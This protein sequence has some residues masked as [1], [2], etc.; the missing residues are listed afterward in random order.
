MYTYSTTIRLHHTDA[1]GFIY[2]PNYF[3][4]AT[5]CFESFLDTSLPLSSLLK[6]DKLNFPVVHAAVDCKIPLIVSNQIAIEMV[7][8]KSGTTSF[9]LGF[10]FKLDNVKIA[11]SVEIV[12]VAV[13]KKAGMPISIPKDLL[14][15]LKSLSG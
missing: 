12:H 6:E 15:L 10:D 1:T 4:I 14:T 5:E 3:A 9:T 7:L 8:R 11:A 13:D 2:F